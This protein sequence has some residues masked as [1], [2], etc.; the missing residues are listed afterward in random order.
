MSLFPDR[1]DRSMK[2][3]TL[4]M[5]R[6]MHTPRLQ[7]AEVDPM[8]PKANHLRFLGSCAL[9]LATFACSG[10]GDPEA[11]TVSASKSAANVAITLQ[12][13]SGTKLGTCSGTL[14]G[15][16]TVITAAH[17]VVGGAAQWRISAPF[18]N[19]G[20]S[21]IA[22]RTAMF[23]WH[24]F[25][26]TMSHPYHSD[27]ALIYL[28]SAIRLSQYPKLATTV[29]PDGTR[30]T[31]VRQDAE[32]GFSNVSVA[33]HAGSN[34]GFPRYY[35]SRT[36]KGEVVDTGGGLLDLATNTLYGVVSARGD[37]TLDMYM[38]RVD[39]LT[40]WVGYEQVCATAAPVQTT[41]CGGSG[42]EDAGTE[43]ASG[44]QDDAGSQDES[45]GGCSG[46][47]NNGGGSGCSGGGNNGG[48][49]N[50]GGSGCSGGG[51]SGGG[52]NGGGSNGGGSG[53]SGGGC[54]GGGNNG[55]GSNGGGGG[56][57]GGGSGGGGGGSGG[58]GSGGGGHSGQPDGGTSC[59]LPDGGTPTFDAGDNGPPG[60]GSGS[61]QTNGNV[62][63]SGNGGGLPWGNLPGSGNGN[64]N[65]NG[66]P[67]GNL[68][69]SGTGSGQTNGNLGG[70]GPGC[71]D[72]S[73]GGCA[74]PSCTDNDV[75]YGNDPSQP[76]SQP[77][78]PVQVTM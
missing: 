52:N 62:P 12:D 18:A 17:C 58:G 14:I 19:G 63:G 48:G 73:C 56:G 47:G 28:D 24:D 64:G 32:N 25:G 16:T 75:D 37:A 35:Y 71:V 74:V 2:Q 77:P 54:S 8:H 27:A 72:S 43:D 7:V 55:G 57:S 45:G 53:C 4:L 68:P 11:I 38:T 76:V 36:Q 15:D 26:S 6:V 78:P 29:A 46:G 51:C 5:D 67:N 39:N 20:Q 23:D 34:V 22:T 13:G 10:S 61:G 1:H 65:G 33:T 69:G 3:V 42:F 41:E 30:L 40:D 9:L 66:Q 44:S 70:D 50:G 59:V 49:N 60:S 21:A 31:R